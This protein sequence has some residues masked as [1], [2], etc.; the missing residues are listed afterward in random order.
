MAPLHQKHRLT[1]AAILSYAIY[2]QY[3]KSA[4]VLIE[5]EVCHG[6]HKESVSSQERETGTGTKEDRHRANQESLHL[7][8]LWQDYHRKEASVQ[9]RQ[10]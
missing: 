6:S 3:I 5:K 10:D 7:P 1:K 4:A 8:D 9:S 2:K